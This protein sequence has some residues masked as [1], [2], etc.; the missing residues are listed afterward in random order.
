[1]GR[2]KIENTKSGMVLSSDVE[3][4]RG[5]VL[6]GAGE[7]ILRKNIRIFKMWGITEVDIRA[8]PADDVE[9]GGIEQLE[10]S[11]PVDVK[12]QIQQFFQHTDLCHPA[13]KELVR[14][15]MKRLTSKK[16]TETVNG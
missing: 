8:I 2:I 13:I 14:I 1:M 6:L 12:S 15:R 10:P 11:T 7:K 5:S 4:H 16:L 9:N 3:D